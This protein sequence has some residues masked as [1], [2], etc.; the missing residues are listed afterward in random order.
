MAGPQPRPSDRAT[1]VAGAHHRK[2]HLV[3]LVRYSNS[4]G[5]VDLP[6]D[7]GASLRTDPLASEQLGHNVVAQPEPEIV[8]EHRKELTYLLCQAAEV[9]HGLMCQYLY[10]AFSLKTAPGPGLRE[11]Q[12]EAVERWRSEILHIAAEEMLHWALVQNLLTAVG[13][14]PYVSRPHMPH[15]AKGY[16]LGVQ[17]RLLAFGEASLQHFIYLERPE[18]MD[19]SDAEGFEPVGEAPLPMARG[20]LQPRAQ[21]PEFEPAHPVT[22][23]GVRGVE[24]MYPDVFITNSTTADVSDLF[25]AM[26]DLLLQMIARYFAFGHET[27]E[28]RGILAHAAVE[29]MFVAIK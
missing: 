20:Q 18:G 3:L 23:A 10:A 2:S 17:L 19:M 12:L 8:I 27:S 29:L 7:S 11:D 5:G 14:A 21:D 22:A 1:N 6:R 26:Y 16:P 28:Q 24:G 25:N 9:E 13:S 4:A 15:Q